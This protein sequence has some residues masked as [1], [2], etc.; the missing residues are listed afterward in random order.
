LFGVFLVTSETFKNDIQYQK[1]N[2]RQQMLNEL[3]LISGS[4]YLN[5]SKKIQ[6]N[7]SSYLK[8]KK[9]VWG[10]FKSLK[11]EPLMNWQAVNSYIEWCF[12]HVLDDALIF[13]NQQDHIIDL[14]L[15]NGLC[16]PALAFAVDGTRLGRGRGFYDRELKTY[17]NEKIGICF[18]QSIRS[19]VP[20][21]KHDMKV[22]V[23]I[24][25]QNTFKI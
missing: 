20:T 16:I 11:T 14:N 22:N 13:K 15:L 7:L 6:D 3:K 17:K 19:D 18:Q 25:E 12:V 23:I 5:R 8:D 4:E 24:T 10:C 2:Y 1:H 9:G 21:E